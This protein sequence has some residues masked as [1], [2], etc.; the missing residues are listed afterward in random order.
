MIIMMNKARWLRVAKKLYFCGSELRPLFNFPCYYGGSDGYIYRL[1]S[2][3]P[4]PY[5]RRLKSQ[6]GSKS[7]RYLHVC[8]SYRGK[9]SVC[10]VHRLIATAFY[11]ACPKGMCCSHLNGD[12]KDNQSSNLCWESMRDNC[13]RKII[14]GTD[15]CGWRNS[16][17]LMSRSKIIKMKEMIKRK[18]KYNVIAGKFKVQNVFVRKV[19]NGSRY[20]RV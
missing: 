8:L 1:L 2:E 3:T 19:A 6:R 7:C 11:S 5:F 16:R 4:K 10:M 18:E 9:I 15:D 20:A 13:R 12:V 17:A 14:H